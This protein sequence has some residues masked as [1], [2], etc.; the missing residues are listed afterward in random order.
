MHLYMITEAIKLK[1]TSA[2]FAELYGNGKSIEALSD[3]NKE[4]IFSVIKEDSPV[5]LQKMTAHYYTPALR[6]YQTY[7]IEIKNR[8]RDQAAALFSEKY[9]YY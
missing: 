4:W 7:I 9:R 6:L 2:H 1:V 8:K 5:I 3:C